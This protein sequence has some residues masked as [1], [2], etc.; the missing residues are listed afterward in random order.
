MILATSY[1]K[2]KKEG[3]A[4]VDRD[5]ERAANISFQEKRKISNAELAKL[6]GAK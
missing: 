4:K 5:L 1:P 2:M 6:L 3:R